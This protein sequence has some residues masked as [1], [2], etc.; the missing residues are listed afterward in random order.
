V[1]WWDWLPEVVLVLLVL[2][3]AFAG[4]VHAFVAQ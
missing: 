1:R 2:G 3:L 4:A